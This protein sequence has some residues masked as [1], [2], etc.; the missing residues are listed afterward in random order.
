VRERNRERKIERKRE[1]SSR[2]GKRN[3]EKEREARLGLAEPKTSTNGGG[4]E[5]RR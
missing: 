3:A 2:E 1:E 5:C 4:D